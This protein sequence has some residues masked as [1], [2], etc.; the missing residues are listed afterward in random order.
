MKL[1]NIRGAGWLLLYRPYETFDRLFN[2][3]CIKS[4]C[5]SK[6]DRSYYYFFFLRDFSMP[7]IH[8]LY[9]LRAR[10]LKLYAR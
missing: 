2:T 10:Q 5:T 8:P 4:Y 6:I 1:M 3:Y 7:K 9:I